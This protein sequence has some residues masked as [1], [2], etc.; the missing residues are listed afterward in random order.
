MRILKI[1]MVA[2]LILAVSGT[3]GAITFNQPYSGPIKFKLESWDM[4]TLYNTSSIQNDTVFSG[5]STLDGLSQ[6]PPPGT[7]SPIPSGKYAGQTE[8]GWGI[9]RVTEI[10]SDDG[11]GTLLWSSATDNSADLVGMFYGS[12]DTALYIDSVAGQQTIQSDGANFKLYAQEKGIFDPAQGSSN[13]VAFD[14]YNTV[15]FAADGSALASSA[16]VLEGKATAGVNP[17]SDSEPASQL[18]S[19]AFESKR[20]G[21]GDMF[22]DITGGEWAS[23]FE[24]SGYFDPPSAD[25]DLFMQSTLYDIFN[26]PTENFDWT[27]VNDDPIRGNITGNVIPEPISMLTV[28]SGI[29][30]LA[31]YIRKR[32]MA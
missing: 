17:V 11:L 29:G 2:C 1:A 12:V 16:L 7:V 32:R 27:V 4:G 30:C 8:D 15:G 25:G 24:T 20:G 26:P 6:F 14:K 18:T 5:V 3:A 23:M 13:R 19:F 21:K 31:G 10:R 28:I 22:I 9:F